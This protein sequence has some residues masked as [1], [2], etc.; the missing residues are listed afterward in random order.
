MSNDLQAFEQAVAAGRLEAAHALRTGPLLE[1]LDLEDATEFDDWLRK[2]ARAVP[3][4]LARRDVASTPDGS[5]A[6]AIVVPPSHVHRRLLDD[7][8]LQE[9]TYRDLMRLHDALGERGAALELYGRC[10]A[11]LREELG[12]EPLPETRLLAERICSEPAS[13]CRPGSTSASARTAAGRQSTCATFP[14]SRG[15]GSWPLRRRC[16][17]PVLLIEGE[18]GVGKSRFARSWLARAGLR[19][20][21]TTG[22]AVLRFG[23]MSASTPFYAVADALR[24]AAALQRIVS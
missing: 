5:K 7:D 23:E 10:E 11:T 20:R 4:R 9:A 24:S 12:L 13:R 15:N 17:E 19:A 6:Q 18:A 14:W 16:L 22:D 3:P 1:G 2:P 8:A 21:P